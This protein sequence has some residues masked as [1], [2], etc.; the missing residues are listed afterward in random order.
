MNIRELVEGCAA[1]E[2]SRPRVYAVM[3]LDAFELARS[4]LRDPTR[5]T[6]GALARD[7]EGGAVGVRYPAAVCW[8]AEGVLRASV[9]QPGVVY[10]ATALLQE[11]FGEPVHFYNDTHS[12]EAVIRGFDTVIQGLR[13]YLCSL[14]APADISY[15]EALKAT[16]DVPVR[17]VEREEITAAR[18]A[19]NE[20]ES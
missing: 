12:H 7:M 6:Q 14:A 17:L 9:T 16:Q 10:S 13:E 1:V 4:T 19:L 5:W 8:C 18:D 20:S 2:G 3:L 11:V 15:A